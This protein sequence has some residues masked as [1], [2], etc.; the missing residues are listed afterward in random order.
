MELTEI[1]L[2]P[3]I[4][5]KTM[6]LVSNGKYTILVNK[7]AN[8]NQ[9]KEAFKKVYK[10]DPIKINVVKIKE[11]QKITRTK[12]GPMVKKRKSYKKVIIE[13]KKGQKIAGFEAEK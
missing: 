12:I 2:G 7:K 6:A 10:V 8:K 5:E 13:L 9:I 3:K 4:T 11:R 1:I